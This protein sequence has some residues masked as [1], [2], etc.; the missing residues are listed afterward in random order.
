VCV[1]Q[2]FN[3]AGGREIFGCGHCGF[4]VERAAASR[5]RGKTGKAFGLVTN[6]GVR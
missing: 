1:D 2:S 5:A 3:G 6:A 4:L